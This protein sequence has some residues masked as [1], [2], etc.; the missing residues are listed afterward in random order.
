[1]HYNHQ[2]LSLSSINQ[3]SLKFDMYKPLL[4]PT[5]SEYPHSIAKKTRLSVA[6]TKVKTRSCSRVGTAIT[7]LGQIEVV[8]QEIGCSAMV[9]ELKKYPNFSTFKCCIGKYGSM[10]MAK[11]PKL[12]EYVPMTQ[13]HQNIGLHSPVWPH[14]PDWAP[15][16]IWWSQSLWETTKSSHCLL[17]LKLTSAS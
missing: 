13:T 16:Y 8:S 1:M 6:K 11:Q 5:T 10:L 4:H 2:V 9:H 3:Y 14:A 12:Y 17:Y 15:N 7:N